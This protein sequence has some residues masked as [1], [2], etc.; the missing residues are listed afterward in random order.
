MIIHKPLPGVSRP[1]L[2]RFTERARRAVRLPGKV[3]VVLAA[4]GEVRELNRLYRG[5]DSAT[6]VL[7]F[8][9]IPT[10]ADDFGGDIIVASDVAAANARRFGHN[11]QHE[12]KILILH[13][14]LHLAGYDHEVDD[15]RMARREQR[16]RREL[17]LASGLIERA[18]GATRPGEKRRRQR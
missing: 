18:N 2:A 15:G 10:V 5:K 9:P 4:K 16:L 17:G 12:I 7:S 6:D 11:A 13:A 1:A 3:N 14:L 8:P